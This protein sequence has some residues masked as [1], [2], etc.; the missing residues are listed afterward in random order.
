MHD[1]AEKDQ[2]LAD[3][4]LS[5]SEKDQNLA[6]RFL[7]SSEKDQSLADRLFPNSVGEGDCFADRLF[8]EL[9]PSCA[10]LCYDAFHHS[11]EKE[12]EDCVR[13]PYRGTDYVVWV[14]TGY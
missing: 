8:T 1:S 11:S 2:S 14:G 3:R 4:F 12:E 9:I 10:I 7:S 13:S 6:D 5:S